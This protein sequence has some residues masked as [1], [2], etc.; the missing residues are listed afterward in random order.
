MVTDV[1][2][3][4]E[5]PEPHLTYQDYLSRYGISIIYRTVM[6]P[7]YFCNGKPYTGKMMSLY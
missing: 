3:Y 6:R 2:N 7:P 5:A 1:L 4:A